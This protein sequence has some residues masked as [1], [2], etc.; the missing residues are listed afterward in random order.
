[1]GE[2][3]HVSPSYSSPLV[4]P[5]ILHNARQV[6]IPAWD[7][8]MDMNPRH[9]FYFMFRGFWTPVKQSGGGYVAWSKGA[10]SIDYPVFD[11]ADSIEM[12]LVLRGRPALAGDQ[13]LTVSLNGRQLGE[14]ALPSWEAGASSITVTLPSQMLSHGVN[15]IEF[16]TDSWTPSGATG[17]PD[18]RELGFLLESVRWSS[19]TSR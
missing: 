2:E 18:T 17:S 10:S 1:M 11:P 16:G 7:E 9:D 15:S 8:G 3:L 12:S 5:L 14:F 13:S 19:G 6:N 4:E